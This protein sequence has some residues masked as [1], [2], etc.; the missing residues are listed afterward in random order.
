MAPELVTQSR[1]SSCVDTV[2]TW[3]SVVRFSHTIFAL[4]FAMSMALI[5]A[6]YRPITLTEI[7]ALLLALISARTAAMAF[8]RLL[9]AEIDAKNPRTADRELPAGK[10]KRQSVRLLFVTNCLLFF[11]AS[12]LLGTHCLVLAP[13]VLGILLF[14]SYTKRFTAGAHFV[15]GLALALAPGGVWY[16]LTATVSMTPVYL[17]AAVLFWVAGFDILYSCQDY[18]FDRS[19]GLHSVPVYTGVKGAF[20]LARISHFIAVVL[21]AIFGVIAGMSSIYFMGVAV[22]ALLLLNQHLIIAPDDLG[23]INAAFF[24]RNGLASVL[25]FLFVLIDYLATV[26]KIV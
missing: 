7:F 3:G 5:V 10:V 13:P 15:L 1:I 11:F 4:P 12:W 19:E 20:L 18:E 14:Y 23:R 16:A 21:L 25:F 22:F 6:R 26:Y 9:D 2:K 8:N 24:S 17:M